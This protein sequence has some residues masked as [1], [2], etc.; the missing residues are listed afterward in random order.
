MSEIRCS[1]GGIIL[2]DTEDWAKPLCADCY[3]DLEIQK[4]RNL[5]LELQDIKQKKI[6]KKFKFAINIYSKT[7]NF[8]GA[9]NDMVDLLREIK[10][11]E[12]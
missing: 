8:R 3:H 7:T 2:A 9:Q 6:I 1:C 5:A 4:T 12:K 10:E 11:L